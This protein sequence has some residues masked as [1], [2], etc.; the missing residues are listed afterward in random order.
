MEKQW[1]KYLVFRLKADIPFVNISIPPNFTPGDRS[2][3]LMETMF[4]FSDSDARSDASDLTYDNSSDSDDSSE[5][6]D[7][8]DED[9]LSRTLLKRFALHIF[10][11][12]SGQQT[13]WPDS[14]Q[15]TPILETL[16]DR[17]LNEH[18]AL[19]PQN[20]PAYEDQI[21]SN[22]HLFASAFYVANSYIRRLQANPT[23]VRNGAVGYV[24]K[25]YINQK[26]T[27]KITNWEI[28]CIQLKKKLKGRLHWFITRYIRDETLMPEN[29]QDLGDEILGTMTRSQ[30]AHF[31]ED[32][33]VNVLNPR[34]ILSVRGY[35][36]RLVRKIVTKIMAN[37]FDPKVSSIQRGANVCCLVP[38]HSYGRKHIKINNVT[39]H[40]LVHRSGFPNLDQTDR[41]NATHREFVSNAASCAKWF[42]ILFDFTRMNVP[43]F[44]ALIQDI[45]P[46]ANHGQRKFINVIDTDGT[47]F[48]ALFRRPQREGIPDLKPWEVGSLSNDRIKYLDPG[49]GSLYTS[50]EARI[51]GAGQEF[52]DIRSFNTKEYYVEAGFNEITVFIMICL[53]IS[54]GKKVEPFE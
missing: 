8:F 17:Y 50:K 46:N 35:L 41:P 23:I 13:R 24:T 26:L 31:H 1:V 30:M 25:S 51:N 48:S 6:L 36:C 14:V 28:W 34:A 9:N 11:L 16:R 5:T 54:I 29:D 53:T 3:N 10:K 20:V 7:D 43:S 40:A 22:P 32:S 21:A 47:A 49:R 38:L 19:F 33:T 45:V 44:D 4:P 12:L 18:H 2:P 52:I 15:V 42:W 27:S 37:T 39:L